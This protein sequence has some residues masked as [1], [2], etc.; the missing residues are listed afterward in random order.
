[1]TIIQ[2]SCENFKLH[3]DNRFQKTDFHMSAFACGKSSEQLKA[4]NAL[5]WTG[6]LNNIRACAR[7]I[8]EKEIIFAVNKTEEDMEFT[9]QAAG[10]QQL[11]ALEHLTV[12]AEHLSDRNSAK[13]KNKI[14]TVSTQDITCEAGQIQCILK[15]YLWKCLKEMFSL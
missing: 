15:P 1:M 12:T 13:E 3:I 2:V 4:E 5:E 14:T 10:F 8:V 6:C 7:E 11:Q 9:V